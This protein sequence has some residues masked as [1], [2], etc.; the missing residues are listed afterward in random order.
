MNGN[1]RMH[2]VLRTGWG[3]SSG[4]HECP[5]CVDTDRRCAP[6]T[7]RGGGRRRYPSR[8][9]VRVIADRGSGGLTALSYG[10]S[11]TAMGYRGARAKDRGHRSGGMYLRSGATAS[12][13]PARVA[14]RR[15]WTRG[16]NRTPFGALRARSFV[17]ACTVI[18]NATRMAPWDSR[19]VHG[20]GSGAA[21]A[22]WF[23]HSGPLALR[24]PPCAGCSPLQLPCAECP[25][26]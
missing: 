5:R 26:A 8:G 6:R 20:N 14:V 2:R 12:R 25:G 1:V 3:F 17:S 15:G 19:R 22:V 10:V 16:S 23:R 24:V 9:E 11:S 7:G 18:P 4:A 21:R 13:C